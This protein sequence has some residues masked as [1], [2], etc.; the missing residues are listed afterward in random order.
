MTAGACEDLNLSSIVENLMI[1]HRERWLRYVQ[2]VVHDRQDA[3]DVLQEAALRM[4]LRARRFQSLDQARMYLGRIV[5]N[6]AI[7]FYHSRRRTQLQYRPLHEHLH[8]AS[9]HGE[10]ERLFFEREKLIANV[11]VLGLVYEGLARLPLKQYEA[12]RLTIMDP[13]VVSIRDAGIENNIPYSTL[14]HRSVQGIRLLRRFLARA[15]RS[16]SARLAAAG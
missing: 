16:S 7:E 11:R 15:L 8:C 6:I 5:S 1:C 14:R 13:D 9:S 3:E 4:L 10:P 2:R 12:V